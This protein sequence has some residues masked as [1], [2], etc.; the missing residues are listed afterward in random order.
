MSLGTPGPTRRLDP[1]PAEAPFLRHFAWGWRIL[2]HRVGRQISR[3]VLE[4]VYV[5]VVPWFALAAA[6]S[7][8][9]LALRS[10]P[11]RWDPAPPAPRSVDECRRGF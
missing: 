2:A 6:A 7:R 4:L 5:A 9:P 10:R 8:D 1:L 11:P 3:A